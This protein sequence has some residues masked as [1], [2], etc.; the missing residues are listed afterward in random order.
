RDTL[1]LGV[2]ADVAIDHPVLEEDAVAA[3]RVRRLGRR[4]RLA[5]ARCPCCAHDAASNARSAGGSASPPPCGE[6]SGVEGTLNAGV[7]ESPPPGLPH[8]GGGEVGVRPVACGIVRRRAA[9]AAASRALWRSDARQRA[10]RKPSTSGSSASSSGTCA[11]RSEP[12]NPAKRPAV[13]ASA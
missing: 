8:K 13:C 10:P 6:G 11:R 4:R 3:E 12:A 5:G 9:S 7:W 2:D 1:L